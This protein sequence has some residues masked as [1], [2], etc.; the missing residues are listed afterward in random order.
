MFHIY[1]CKCFIWMLHILAM[2]FKCFSCV[3]QV[4]QMYVVGVSSVF[5]RMLQVFHLDVAKAD[6]V[7]HMLQC[8]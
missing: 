2:A 7:F 4:F 5:E 8:V 3:L 1:I 6:R